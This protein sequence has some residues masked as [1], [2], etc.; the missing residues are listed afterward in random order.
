MNYLRYKHL[1]EVLTLSMDKKEIKVSK[2]VTLTPSTIK[3]GIDLATAK[4]RSFSEIVEVALVEFYK[5]EGI[6]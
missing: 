1:K 5:K 3:T 4:N 2:N 6:K